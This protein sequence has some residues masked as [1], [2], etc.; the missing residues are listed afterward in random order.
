M[1]FE[2]VYS[3]ERDKVQS[4]LCLNIFHRSVIPIPAHRGEGSITEAGLNPCVQRLLSFI[5]MT[6]KNPRTRLFCVFIALVNVFYDYD[7][8]VDCYP[9]VQGVFKAGGTKILMKLKF[10]AEQCNDFEE[11]S[12]GIG[13]FLV[14]RYLIFSQINLIPFYICYCRS[15]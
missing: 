9:V 7:S 15:G 5:F 4:D 1:I 3:N 2:S 13:H 10:I 11:I 14:S 6:C 8:I 12:H